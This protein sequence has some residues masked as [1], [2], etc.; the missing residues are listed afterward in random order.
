MIAGTPRE[1]K[2][3]HILFYGGKEASERWTA[4]KDQVKGNK[5]D[6]DTVFKA[7]ANS[8]EKSSSHW[9]ARDEYLSDIKQ[10]KNQTTAELDIYIKDLIR[11]CQFPPEDQES[12]KIDLLYHATAH[13]EVRKFIHNAKHEE[14]KYDRMIEVAK[15]HE[16]TCQEY[17]IHK[18]AHSMANPSNSYSNPLIQTNALSKSFQKGPPKKTCGKCRCSHSHGDC[19]AHGTTCSKCGHLYHWAQQCRSSGRRNSSTSHSP[20]LGRPQNRQRRFSSNKPN[21]G[22]G[23][24]RGGNV[25]QKSTPKRPGSGRG[26]GGGK[27]FKM[28]ALTVTGL[29]RSQHPPKVDGP[30]GNETKESVSMNAD[31]PRPAHP[32]KVSG[33]QFHN[34]FVCDA[35][36]S[37]GNELYDP[38]SNKGKAYT[39]TDSDGK[40]EIITD[41]TCK[42][43]GKLIAM[44]VKVD[45]G[46]ETNCIPLS[47]FRRLFP[48][49]CRKDGTPKE[50]ALE[51]TLAQFEAYDGGIMTSHRWIILP[52]QD[53]RDSNKFHPLRYYVVTREEARI[54]I[55]HATATWLGLMKVLCPNKVP[56]IK[57]QVAS[58]SK[59]ASEPSDSNN[60]NSL[61]GPEHPPK[62]KY[63]PNNKMTTPQHPPKVKYTG[64][65]MIKE[66]QYELPT[67]KPCSHGRRCHRGRPAH[68]E[69]E[70][71]V[72]N[73][74]VKF[75]SFHINNSGA[76][77]MGGRQSM[78]PRQISTPSQS[79]IKSISNN[80][81]CS[82][83][84]RTTTSSQSEI[85]GFLP[86]RQYYQPQE[87][88]DTYYI[89][90]EGHL[91]CHQHSQNIIKA[92]TPQ[93]LPRSK[94]HP[95]FYKPGSIKISS[96][97]DLLRL[98]PNS[99][100]R[101]GSL[102]GEYDIKVDPTVPPVQHAR[103][104]VP[105]ESKAA[106]EE[107]IDYMVKQDILEPQI[108]PTPWV[109]SVTYPVKPSGEVRPCLDA[110]DLNKAIIRENHKP[111]TVEEIAH[112]LAGAVVFTKADALKA[113]LQ[114]HL[115][116]ESSKL[117]VI[118]THKGRYRFKRMPFRAKMSQDVFQM[119]MDLI[120]ERCPGVISIHDDIVVYSVSEED[121][122]ANLVNLLNVAQI[123]GLVLNSKKLE[124]KRPRVS[125]FG[126]E[127]SADGMHPC[128]KKIQGITEMTPPTDKQQL[129]SF[130]GMVL[131][132]GNFVPHLSHH[133]EP[134]RAMLKQEAVFAWD[135]MAN[136]S[137]Q[138]I[139]DL[140]AKSATKPLRYYDR[141]KPVTVQADASQRG[142]GACLLQDG[143]PIAY[144]S[145]SFTDTET[146]YANIERELLAIVFACQQFNTYVLG[147][148][149]TVESDH[150]PLEMIHQ[151]SLASAPPRLQRML[152]QLQRYD[153]TIRY[154][155]G[156]EMLLTDALSRCPS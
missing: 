103:R 48:Q 8:F 33:E 95:I 108:E 17:Q 111:Q 84:S 30:G 129:A 57:R 46:S 112:Q 143:Q 50:N 28:N 54:L 93:E 109:S 60:S 119:K 31:L 20:S 26:R 154:R 127:Y 132:M 99:F 98:Y 43:K 71:Q 114:V 36:I 4:L 146:R 24:G 83:T 87:D 53:M 58:V 150:K 1:A 85:S 136:A 78:L 18:Q 151:K 107:A 135:E 19:P 80:H 134:L 32:P 21:K 131:Y 142:L 14:L 13:F 12:C 34:T 118:N 145:K 156:K 79:E 42:F 106:I 7:F 23:R 96:V 73:G 101:L 51:P 148:P 49:L 25:K 67:S 92:P 44:E 133:T 66:Q 37:N 77:S 91:Q 16:R 45:P 39:D 81:Y 65:V 152:L 113:F 121:H 94:E 5:D 29:S 89:N 147:R 52:T 124:L 2:V 137:F 6:A 122:D 110:R 69:E 61:S 82:S 59:K 27:P 3:T 63:F 144:T 68:R 120:M 64:T 155:P 100:D 86:K 10:D 128:P 105:I 149:F 102:E 140:I 153:A 139:K 115:T 75:Q 38:P 117:L 15:A 116:E 138:K 90:S 41:I 70:D 125:F 74:P 56:R 97:E 62:A 40:T 130:I 22:R 11:R 126:V 9:Q 76:T 104:K 141:T 88:E 35:L 55:S 123:E 72:A 47:H